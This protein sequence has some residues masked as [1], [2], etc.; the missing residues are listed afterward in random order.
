VN[1]KVHNNQVFN[2]RSNKYCTIIS[3]P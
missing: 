2:D 1:Y 3:K